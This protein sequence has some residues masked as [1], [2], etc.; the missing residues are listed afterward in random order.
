M[1]PIDIGVHKKPDKTFKVGYGP[2]I[3]IGNKIFKANHLAAVECYWTDDNLVG[4]IATDDQSIFGYGSTLE[5]AQTNFMLRIAEAL[6]TM[7]QHNEGIVKYEMLG[8]GAQEKRDAFLAL[9]KE[10]EVTDG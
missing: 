10:Q 8:E 7:I 5:D 2:E 9:F 6:R 3:K 4:V 1:S